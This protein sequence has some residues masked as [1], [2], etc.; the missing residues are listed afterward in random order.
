M[1]RAPL[2]E[3]EATPHCC[4]RSSGP[5]EV[6]YGQLQ[7]VRHLQG[8]PGVVSAGAAVAVQQ[9]PLGLHACVSCAAL[10]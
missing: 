9:P 10:V 4:R 8:L 5:F 7:E 2:F 1:L 6:P 3:P